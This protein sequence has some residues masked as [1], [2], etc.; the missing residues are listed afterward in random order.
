MKRL[1]II[2]AMLMCQAKSASHDAQAEKL[3]NSRAISI[4]LWGLQDNYQ[5][6]CVLDDQLKLCMQAFIQ[7]EA[8]LKGLLA[9]NSIKCE[10]EVENPLQLVHKMIEGTQKFLTSYDALT[11]KEEMIF[12]NICSHIKEC[13]GDFPHPTKGRAL[14]FCTY[15]HRNFLCRSVKLLFLNCLTVQDIFSGVLECLKNLRL[16]QPEQQF[17]LFWLEDDVAIGEAES[18]VAQTYTH[19]ATVQIK[20]YMALIDDKKNMLGREMFRLLGFNNSVHLS[21]VKGLYGGKPQSPV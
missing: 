12:S 4:R 9:N 5:D 19:N 14:N 20:S 8:E 16:L 18:G 21:V 13:L 10:Q 17:C 11:E 7:R 3:E 6:G 1:M 15:L 2:C